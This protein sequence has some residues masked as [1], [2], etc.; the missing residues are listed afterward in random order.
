MLSKDVQEPMWGLLITN[1]N[2]SIALKYHEDV[3]QKAT[4]NKFLMESFVKLQPI[5]FMKN[6]SGLRAM[7]N[8]AEGN[9][10]NLS[11]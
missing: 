6:V 4:F 10:C 5:T 8:L 9:V 7:Y 2:H 1:W 3:I 11:S